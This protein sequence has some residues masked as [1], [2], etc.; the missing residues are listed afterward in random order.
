MPAVWMRFRSEVRAGA[1]GLIGLVL[2]VGLAGGIVLGAAAGARRTETAF[3]RFLVTS[4]AA[5]VLVS[6]QADDARP[7]NA[8]VEPLPEVRAAAPIEACVVFVKH[9]VAGQPPDLNTAFPGY[10][11]L[12]ERF[13]SGIDRPNV[14]TGRLPNPNRADEAVMNRFLADAD[15]TRPSFYASRPGAFKVG[16]RITLDDL[17]DSPQ[18]HVVPRTLTITG[19]VV[20]P[21]EVVPNSALDSIPTLYLTPAF[22][23][24]RG[25]AATCGGIEL[26]LKPGADLDAFRAA[27]TKIGA[28][29]KAATG[30]AT[31][32]QNYHERNANVL[33][34][35]RP[36]ALALWLFAAIAG[37]TSIVVLGQILSRQVSLGSAEHPALRSLGM[38]RRQLVAVAMTRHVVVCVV[39]AAVAAM[40]ATAASTLMPI[41]PAR[42]AEPHPGLEFNAVVV[43]LGALGFALALLAVV[44]IPS[45]RAAGRRSETQEPDGSSPIARAV[46]DTALPPAASVGISMALEP[47]RGQ[48]AV[49]V[50][51]AMLGASVAIGAVVVALVFG[52]S[53]S[54]L[55]STPQLYGW[56]WDAIVDTSF[57]S[58]ARHQ[59]A[60]LGAVPGVAEIAAGHYGDVSI[61][62]KTVPAIGIDPIKGRVFPRLTEGRAPGKANEIVLGTKVASRLHAHVGDVLRVLVEQ[63]PAPHSMRVVG[64]G[65]FPALGRGSFAPTSLGEGAAVSGAAMPDEGGTAAYAF[66]LVRFSPGVNVRDVQARIRRVMA[67]IPGCDFACELSSRPQQ[68]RPAVISNYARVR[69]TPL[70]LAGALALLAVATLAHTLVSAVGRRRRDLAVL[71][72]LGFVRGQVSRLV[73]WQATTVAVVALVIAVPAGVA[74][75][76]WTWRSFTTQLGVPSPATVPPIAILVVPV[77]LVVANVVA[78]IPARAAGR[79]RPALVLRSE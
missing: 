58:M 41:G 74:I 7:F 24:A 38:T 28:E 50:R 14:L 6:T 26:R 63:D 56:S 73:V 72:T 12:D 62:G 61:G 68:R 20:F 78:A 70:V 44:A 42:L 10:V 43:G 45:W 65:V 34:A 21:N 75:G 18:P 77:A 40:I 25:G 57:G 46:A 76:R 49:P 79:T 51:S 36:Q 71:K 13:M 16:Q 19:E 1:R 67:T 32:I 3:P 64:I 37:L 30:G 5:D 4:G 15:A 52:T 48:T 9:A 39:G 29:N 11:G 2:L 47:G 33:R 53:L 59:I 23:R 31:F 27:I 66:A 60:S 54:H 8:L 22:A 35:I 55:V 69:V 17:I